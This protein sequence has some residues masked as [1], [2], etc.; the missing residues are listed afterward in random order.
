MPGPKAAAPPPSSNWRSLASKIN[1]GK[2]RKRSASPAT[3]AASATNAPAKQ[4]QPSSLSPS[5]VAVT[6][7]SSSPLAAP[8]PTIPSEPVNLPELA[9][10]RLAIDAE[11]VGVGD[12]GKR[13]ALAQVVVVSFDERICYSAFVR[14][15]EPITDYR[16]HVSGV[17]P[18]H[19]RHALPLRRVQTE[20]AALLRERT[21]I[22]HALQ[23]DLRALMLEHPRRQVRDTSMYPAYRKQLGLGSRPRKLQALA[24]E[25]L[26]WDIQGAAHS[27]AE[28]AVA[29]LR[30]YKLRMSEWERALAASSGRGSAGGDAA[31]AQQHTQANRWEQKKRDKPRKIKRGTGG[32]RK[33]GGGGGG[34][35]MRHKYK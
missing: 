16:T 13:S 29:A 23:N 24:K 1:V 30:L 28:D 17:R 10:A 35:A 5:S 11:M 22:G 15:P 31:G 33:G 32:G 8:A 34:G 7:S 14:P 9:T 6:A 18:E 2:K 4:Q 26:Q 25:F 3:A 19:M 27:P 12:G 20:V 21:V